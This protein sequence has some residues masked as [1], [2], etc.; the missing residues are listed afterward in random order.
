MFYK[1]SVHWCRRSW[2]F[3]GGALYERFLI[4]TE[5]KKLSDTCETYQNDKNG[6]FGQLPI[7]RCAEFIAC[8]KLLV[9]KV[10]KNINGSESLFADSSA[11]IV[12]DT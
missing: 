3:Q 4:Y 10:G 5:D 8:Y 11:Q 1:K 6:S 9:L 7:P 12:L 2:T